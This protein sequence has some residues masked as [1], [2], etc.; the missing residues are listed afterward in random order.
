M[1]RVVNDRHIHPSGNGNFSA[2]EFLFFASTFWRK[3]QT[4]K[5]EISSK[6]PPCCSIHSEKYTWEPA[7]PLPPHPSNLFLIRLKESLAL[8]VP[9]YPDSSRFRSFQICSTILGVSSP[10]THP[11]TGKESNSK[12]CLYCFIQ[13]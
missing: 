2:A 12:S 11:A 13:S 1:Q 6:Y 5:A 10:F 4:K 7:T 9:L 8:F 3:L